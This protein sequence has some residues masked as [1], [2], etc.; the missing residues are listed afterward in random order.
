MERPF[1]VRVIGSSGA[2]YNPMHLEQYR[3]GFLELGQNC[4]GLDQTESR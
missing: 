2:R 4:I 3:A 1:T